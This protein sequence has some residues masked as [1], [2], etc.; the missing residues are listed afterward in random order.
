MHIHCPSC[1]IKSKEL[2]GKEGRDG[3]LSLL[4]L[5]P[6]AILWVPGNKRNSEHEKRVERG[7]STPWEILEKI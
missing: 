5:R 6:L 2:K 4:T 3:P 7:I 1:G